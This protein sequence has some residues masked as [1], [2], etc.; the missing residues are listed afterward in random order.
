MDHHDVDDGAGWRL[1]LRRTT[2][3]GGVER[4]GPPVLIVPGYQMNSSVFGF[5]PT[6]PSLE[7]YLASRG[8]EVW[9]VDLRGTGRAKRTWGDERFGLAELAIEDLGAALAYVRAVAKSDAVD[10]IGCSLGTALV[11]AHVAC[12]PEAKVRAIVAMG[13]VVT[14][15][16]V[17]R[18]A[19]LAARAPWLVGQLRMRGTRRLARQALPIVTRVAPSLLSMYLNVKSTDTSPAEELSQTVEDPNPTMNREIARWVARRDLVVRGVNVS[20][21][22]GSM[23]MPFLCVVGRQDGI[24]P[25]KTARTVF[26]QLGSS[27]K[28]LLE[29]GDE[30][31][32]I[33]HADLFLARR[34]PELVFAPVA[35]FLLARS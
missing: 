21:A 8:I 30:A 27:D 25:P 29:V 2:P 15:A 35:D 4:R 17:N 18:V 5:H 22:L 7:A 14:W 28:V 23:R 33:A 26:E 13:G 19:R 20:R 24:V 16:H 1:A 34:A 31:T 32:P 12:V 6:G 3:D 10:V 11:F 9:S